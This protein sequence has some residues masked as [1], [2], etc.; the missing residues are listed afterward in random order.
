MNPKNSNSIVVLFFLF[1]SLAFSQMAGFKYKRALGKTTDT[2]HKVVLPEVMFERIENNFSDLR[3]Y[4]ITTQGDTI[5]A[6][7]ILKK[8]AGK[9]KRQAVPCEVLNTSQQGD[10]HYFTLEVP[11]KNAINRLTLDFKEEN[12]DWRLRLEGSMDQR[13]WFTILEDYRILS[14][15]NEA[16]DYQFSKAI[17][18]DS[19][20]RYYRIAINNAIKPALNT[21]AV[22]LLNTVNGSYNKYDVKSIEKRSRSKDRATIVDV[23]LSQAVP[24]SHLTVQVDN[25]YDYYRPLTIRFLKDSLKTEKGWKYQYETMMRSTLT[26]IEKNEF[27]LDAT[28]TKKLQLIIDN[29]DNSPLNI[30]E[31]EVKGYQYELIARL[32]EPANY[33]LT[34][35][36]QSARMPNYDILRFK[37]NIPEVV[38]SLSLG[39]EVLI[40]NA[41]IA[42]QKPLF[43]N[44]IWLWTVMGIII[45]ILGWF[46][47]K[48]MGK[49][50]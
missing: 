6:P 11:T 4:G 46:T 20:Y 31:V 44:K 33:F 7:Y 41:Q 10:T 8:S 5:E 47:F 27:V 35:G 28:I 25:D 29:Y 19:K 21:A 17:F 43:Q 2:W 40:G 30:K 22:S 48:M 9:V 16:T 14:I 3:I 37:E 18:A 38:N 39:E 45:V 24:V 13:Q 32:T 42:S 50:D 36:S 12:F 26:S 1:S 49:T 23:E 34:Y 15:K